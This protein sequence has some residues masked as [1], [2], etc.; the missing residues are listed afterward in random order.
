MTEL[1]LP[2]DGIRVLDLTRV[3]AGPW[4]TMSLGDLGAEVWKI[5]NIKGG[6]DTRA[7]SFP[8]FKGLS[9]YYLCANRGKQSIALDLKSAEG[10]QIVLDLAAK[11]DV[12]VENFRAGTVE[13][14]GIGYEDIKAINP[15][16]IY[17]AISGYGQTGPERDR[18]GYDFIMQAESGLMSITG[19]VDGPP[20]RLGVAFTDVVAGMIATQSILAALYQRRDTGIGQYI[21]VA[22]LD[23][24]LNLLINVGTGFLNAGAEPARYGNAHPTVVPYQIFDASD[25]TFALAVGNDRMFVDFCEHVIK[26][27]ELGRDPRFVTSH[28]RAVHREELLPL[29]AEVVRQD[30]CAH[31]LAACLAASVP[32]GQVKTVS[33]ALKSP[34]VTERGVVQHLEHP[35]LGTVA[36]IRPAHGLAAQANADA[37][38]PPLLG[39]DTRSVLRDVLGLDDARIENL[40]LAGVVACHD[41]PGALTLPLAQGAVA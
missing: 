6:D 2:L 11:A 32:A 1:K 33:E 17:C 22:L 41:V 30:T 13:R 4:A 26:R 8:N 7:W 25:G 14:L 10:R 9:T 5:E 19:Q 37:K 24:T 27:P 34:S 3:L 16:I 20:N 39:E 35:E 29:L 12:V 28:K 40:A 23:A 36:L 31:W 21:D 15:G 18:P 38:A